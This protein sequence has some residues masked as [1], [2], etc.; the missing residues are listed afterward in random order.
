MK[1]LVINTAGMT[2]QLALQADN[3]NYF[4]ELDAS[5]KHSENLL[6]EIEKLLKKAN[7]NLNELEYLAVNVGPGSFTGLRISIATAKA[8]LVTHANLKAVKFNSFEM[9]ANNFFEN[10]KD[11]KIDIVLNAL[12]GLYFVS[13]FE[14]NK[15]S[16]P[17]MIEKSE[18]K[19]LNNIVSDENIENCNVK[20]AKF[21]CENMLKIALEKIAKNETCPESELVPLY[22]RPSQ[23]EANLIKNK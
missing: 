8:L 16:E 15:F 9:L 10:N 18:L 5:M 2:A 11:E 21:T 14:N 22:I 20:L 13:T 1:I 19:K 7:V 12:S 6:P 17:K 3:L 23:A 4:S